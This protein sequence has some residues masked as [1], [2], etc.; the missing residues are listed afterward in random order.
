MP[1]T[2]GSIVAVVGVICVVKPSRL[3][4]L[5][6]ALLSLLPA[7]CGMVV[8]YAA[9][10][11]YA[12]VAASPTPPKPAEFARLTGR[13]MGSSFFGLLGT[14]VPM[15]VAVL[16]LSRAGKNANASDAAA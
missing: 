7:V 5:I 15:F 16:A 6:V 2:L 9:A 11:D 10:V 14:V 4:S 12:Q 8:V 1:L 3:A 13:A